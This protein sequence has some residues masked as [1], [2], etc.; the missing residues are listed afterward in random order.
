MMDQA[1]DKDAIS[2]LNK[3]IDAGFAFALLIFFAISLIAY[4]SLFGL[5]NTVQQTDQTNQV[6][7]TLKATVSEAEEV[8]SN[9]RD[10]LLSGKEYLLDQYHTTGILLDQKIRDL[11]RMTVGNLNQRRWLV[12]LEKLV[13]R[14]R[15]FIDRVIEMRKAQG[16]AAAS[17][18]MQK[19]G[20]E[21]EVD[22]IRKVISEMQEEES[23]N[24]RQRSKEGIAKSQRTIFLI[25][26]VSVLAFLPVA[27][28]SFIIK[29]D[30]LRR[31]HAEKA[32]AELT[33]ELTR[34]NKELERFAHMA[35]HDL[36]E[37][38]RIVSNYTQLLAKRYKGRLDAEADEYMAYA[39]SGAHR[40]QQL[41]ESL[42][43][44]S[45][46]DMNGQEE[47]V[48]DCETALKQA[49][50]NLGPVI[51]KN[52]AAITHDPLPKVV[53]S[54]SQIT[55]LFQNLID[56]AVK[57]RRDEAPRVHISAAKDK[58]EW[59][60]GVKDNGIG[61]DPQYFER[62]FIIFQRLHS[63]ADYPGIG[64]GLAVCKRIV[65]RQGGRIW[66][67]SQPGIGSTFYFTL[68]EGAEK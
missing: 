2:S 19:E 48:V 22:D 31:K 61:I 8:E 12:V 10:Y 64:M 67:A 60:F 5:V 39:V 3:K 17:E 36:Q 56:N 28:A 32:M 1:R 42:L 49:I 18:F 45:K 34:S 58:G 27:V 21:I 59:V 16:L 15:D 62:I 20:Q 46:V 65:E 24:L 25:I 47:A 7:T 6:L 51:E 35:S 54:E 4:R 26:F 57:F 23:Q 52:G 40:M 41:I 29:R 37:P 55:Q 38:L 13:A 66:V 50:G 43:N 68:K 30:I 33:G 9:V 14:K 44:Y 53:A 63:P 11:G